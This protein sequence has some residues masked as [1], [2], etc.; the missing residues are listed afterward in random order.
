MEKL[1]PPQ[2]RCGV[3]RPSPLMNGHWGYDDRA[4]PSPPITSPG[5]QRVRVRVMM[6]EVV[7]VVGGEGVSWGKKGRVVDNGEA[8]TT[9]PTTWFGGMR[10]CKKQT[11]KR[12]W[13]HEAAL[14]FKGLNILNYVSCH[15]VCVFRGWPRYCTISK[16]HVM[17]TPR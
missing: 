10:G 8:T 17:K 15:Y 9:W 7:V 4:G 5:I 3:Q 6:V 1:A 14:Q 13:L 12:A 2:M 11:K 16:C